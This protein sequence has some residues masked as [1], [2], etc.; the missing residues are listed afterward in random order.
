MAPKRKLDIRKRSSGKKQPSNATKSYVDR[1]VAAHG[2][3]KELINSDSGSGNYDF[4]TS[5][6]P[7]DAALSD[8]A[9]GLTSI[10]RVGNSIQPSSLEL[11]LTAYRGTTDSTLRVLVVRYND[12]ITPSLALMS[13]FMSVTE[14]S[15]FNAVNEMKLTDKATKGV[16]T[17][18]YDNSFVLDD[19]SQNGISL[20]KFIKVKGPACQYVTTSTGG[21]QKHAIYMY[22]FSDVATGNSPTV[23]W[24]AKLRFRDV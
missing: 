5:A 8:L 1:R 7:I 11:R 21:A 17:I 23:S 2:E 10:T 3:L 19:G 12:R 6:K 20:H 24:V 15:T 4:V 14:S 22:I 13:G 18:L 16:A 9:Q